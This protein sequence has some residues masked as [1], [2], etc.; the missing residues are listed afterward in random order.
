MAPSAKPGSL[1]DPSIAALFSTKDPEVLYED[2]REIGHGSCGAVFYAQNKNTQETVAIKKMSFSGKQAQE[3]WLDIIKEVTLLKM[4]NHKHI[5]MY[6]DCYLKESTCWLIMEYCVGSCSD[7]IEVLKKPLLEME[8]AAI[9]SQALLGLVFL[10]GLQR[11]HRD[12]KAGNILL[13]DLGIVKLGDLGSVSTSNPAQSFVGTPYFM[14]PEVIM[15]MEDGLYDDRAD[16]WSFGITC[17]EMAEQKPPL[18]NR[19]A[20]SA[21]YHIAQNDPPKLSRTKE[22]GEPT[23]WSTDFHDFIGKCLKADPKTRLTANDCLVHNFIS[24]QAYEN[25]H[26]VILNLIKKTKLI[27]QEQDTS[28]YRKMRKL[29]YLDEQKSGPEYTSD[30]QNT[31]NEED[32]NSH[33][34]QNF[35][36][37]SNDGGSLCDSISSLHSMDQISFQ[38]VRKSSKESTASGNNFRHDNLTASTRSVPSISGPSGR[39]EGRVFGLVVSESTFDQDGST[40]ILS[41]NGLN[42]SVLVGSSTIPRTHPKPVVETI[43][44]DGTLLSPNNV[45]PSTDICNEDNL[46]CGLGGSS[47]EESLSR[48]EFAMGTGNGINHIGG[49]LSLHRSTKDKINTLR[50]SKFSTLRTTKIISKEVDEYKQENNIYEQMVGYKRLRQLHQKELKYQEDRNSA[51]LDSL[52]LKLERE[53]DQLVQSSIREL[54]KCRQQSKFDMDRLIKDHESAEKQGRKDKIKVNNF[55]FNKFIQL[56]KMEYKHNKEKVKVELKSRAMTRSDYDAAV[57]AA[58]SELMAQKEAKENNFYKEQQIQMNVEAFQL[59]RDHLSI[60]KNYESKLMEDEF[61]IKGRQLETCHGM[62]RKH[63]EVTKEKENKCS[64]MVE[65]FRRKHLRTQHET[66]LANQ[67]DYNKRVVDDMRKRHALQ[68]K[69]QPKDLKTKEMLIRKQFRQAVKTQ[70]RQFK[71]YQNQLLQT[72]TKDEQKEL[73]NKLK[74][75]Q[76]RKIAALADQYEAT[77]GNMVS[78]QTIQLESWQVEEEKTVKEKLIKEISELKEFQTRQ[79]E[80]LEMIMERERSSCEERIESRLRDLEEKMENEISLFNEER[81]TKFDQMA[82][83]QQSKLDSIMAAEMSLTDSAYYTLSTANSNNSNSQFSTTMHNATTGVSN[84]TINSGPNS[85]FASPILSTRSLGKRSKSSTQGFSTNL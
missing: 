29:M 45:E 36:N 16:I 2:L 5:V 63:H 14:A 74:D 59:K 6:K 34:Y 35:G 24:K 43:P 64:Q 23:N 13:T 19:P 26:L 46:S 81:Q 80:N 67:T 32:T 31:E 33:Y 37:Q 65:F 84:S 72:A 73:I 61:A 75:E 79:R 71:A 53:Y 40:F 82:L 10:H 50:R 56:Q 1:K 48:D 76:K 30:S 55:K 27:V 49:P 4:L 52:R 8:I 60:Q 58:K 77:I 54:N 25:P 12:I 17:I 51:E 44:E 69:Q 11:I 85:S 22:K 70:T 9:C 47:Q 62:M 66:E 68:S 15:A 3:K 18:F 57:K 39:S 41:S 83:R 7:V 42:D 38:N 20:M 21:L 28:Q 78:E